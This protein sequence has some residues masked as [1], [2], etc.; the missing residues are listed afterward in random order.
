MPIC[1][2]GAKY[3]ATVHVDKAEKAGAELIDNA[4]VLRLEADASGRIAAA[5]FKRPDGAEE[6]VAGDHLRIAGAHDVGAGA[7]EPGRIGHALLRQHRPVGL[8]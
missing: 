8:P 2:V 3:D 5:V 7:R 4:V 6:R 1:P